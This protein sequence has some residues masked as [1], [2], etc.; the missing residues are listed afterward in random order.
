MRI[1]ILIPAAFATAAASMASAK[2]L[3]GQEIAQFL[4]GNT[5][6]GSE[7]GQAYV[8]FLR[9]D[10]TLIGEEKDGRYTGRWGVS[11]GRICF[12][13]SGEDG[14]AGKWECSTVNVNGG[15]VVWGAQSD[16][17]YSRLTA[18]NPRGF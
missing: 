15:N 17:S 14:R 11:G 13:Y 7:N 9:P 2:N 3:S 5:L 4:A 6:S 18:G 8:E 16:R 1:W 12:S 10:G